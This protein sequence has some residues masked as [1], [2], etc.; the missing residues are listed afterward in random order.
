MND[1]KQYQMVPRQIHRDY[2]IAENTLTD[3][4]LISY[5]ESTTGN[6]RLYQCGSCG[7]KR[8]DSDIELAID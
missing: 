1:L 2:C 3:W 5:T 6:V 8:Y 7:N 4:H